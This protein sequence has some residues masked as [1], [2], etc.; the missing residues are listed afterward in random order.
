MKKL[1]RDP[2]RANHLR[3]GFLTKCPNN[4]LNR[5]F[6]SEIRQKILHRCYT[7]PR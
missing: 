5:G 7:A 2:G 4:R 1:T 3:E 6:V